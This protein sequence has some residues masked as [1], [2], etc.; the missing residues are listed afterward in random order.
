MDKKRRGDKNQNIVY[1]TYAITKRTI[2]I[3][4]DSV[5]SDTNGLLISDFS[6]STRGERHNSYYANPIPTRGTSFD[7]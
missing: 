4:A 2:Q 5:I 6:S 1:H 3:Q 7:V